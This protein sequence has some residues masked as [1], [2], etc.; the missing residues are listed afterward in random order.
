[1]KKYRI[2]KEVTTVARRATERF[3]LTNQ[4]ILIA[5]VSYCKLQN[6]DV[7][8]YDLAHCEFDK[9][10]N[11]LLY[12]TRFPSTTEDEENSSGGESPVSPESD[13]SVK[14]LPHGKT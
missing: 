10:N 12:V 6:P 13:T 7:K 14:A 2:A 3:I 8:D 1:M 11:E 9:D 4:E 5:L